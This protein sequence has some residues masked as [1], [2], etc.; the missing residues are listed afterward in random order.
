MSLPHRFTKKSVLRLLAGDVVSLTL[1]R[2]TY[3]ATPTALNKAEML[4]MHILTHRQ[5]PVLRTV[6]T[7]CRRASR[8]VPLGPPYI[9]A[10]IL[11]R[12]KEVLCSTGGSKLR[13]DAGCCG[14]V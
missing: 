11:V 2:H 10:P 14:L 8:P 1:A 7:A 9:C 5:L 13:A 4:C 3:A 12:Q 6:P